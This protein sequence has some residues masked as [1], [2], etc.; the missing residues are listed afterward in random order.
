MAFNLVN[1]WQQRRLDSE[2][3]RLRDAAAIQ[4]IVNPY[5]AVSI[6]AGSGGC[7]HA[8]ELKGRRFLS[9]EAPRMPV[10]DCDAETCA[11]VY[12][13]HDDRRVGR[14]RRTRSAVPRKDR[15]VGQGRRQTDG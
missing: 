1:W 7:A 4:R 5:H 2:I 13:H 11:C 3:R 6:K 10:P 12:T 9:A 15:R 8:L 14:D